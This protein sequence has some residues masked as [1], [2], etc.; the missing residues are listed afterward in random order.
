MVNLIPQNETAAS[1]LE[2]ITKKETSRRLKVC[3]RKVELM[4]N[5][6]EIPVI[7]MG[8]SV[9]FNWPAVLQALENPNHGEAA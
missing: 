8:S 6:G 9:R 1:A 2:L 7:R 4:V 3:V 5:A